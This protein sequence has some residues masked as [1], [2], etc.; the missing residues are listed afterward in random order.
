MDVP[1]TEIYQRNYETRK[2]LIL[3][4]G[5]TGSSKSYSLI[6]LFLNRLFTCHH[7]KILIVRK[8]L[9]SLRRSTYEDFSEMLDRL[10]L[11]SRVT[12]NKTEFLWEYK[13]LKNKIFFGSLDDPGKWKSTGFNDIWMEEAMDCEYKDYSVLSLY[14]RSPETDEMPNQFFISENPVDEYHWSKT[15]IIDVLNKDDFELI[16]STYDDNPFYPE[17]KKKQLEAIAK[18]DP[19]FYRIYRR[20]EWGKLEGLIYT[21]YDIVTEWPDIDNQYFG[22]DFGITHPTAL[23]EHIEKNMEVWEKQWFYETGYDNSMLIKWMNENKVPKNKPIYADSEDLN[24]ISELKKAGYWI[25]PAKKGP[26][27]VKSG[28]VF[29]KSIKYHIHENSTDLKRETRSYSWMMRD[30]KPTD[31]PKKENDHLM[32]ARRYADT[33]HLKRAQ[34]SATTM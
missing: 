23:V 5:G 29:C 28:I 30:E 19:N 17:A 6:Q 1:Y 14:N 4:I 21:N 7:R 24:R 31:E 18:L 9:P 26:G 25:V 13:P 15:N 20:G 34:Y 27:S 8:T 22:L 11:T 10:N 3:N 12:I 2:P 32:D 33:G 16:H